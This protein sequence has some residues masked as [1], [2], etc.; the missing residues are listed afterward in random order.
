MCIILILLESMDLDYMGAHNASG[1]LV[2]VRPSI[3]LRVSL[4]AVARLRGLT[5]KGGNSLEI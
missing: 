4:L 1:F 2:P 5:Q 3:V